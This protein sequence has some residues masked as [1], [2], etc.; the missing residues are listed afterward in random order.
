ML[1][2]L[3]G[4]GVLLLLVGALAA[5]AGGGT[6]TPSRVSAPPPNFQAGDL[7]VSVFQVKQELD[8]KADFDLIDVRSPDEFRKSHIT[9]ARNIPYY[10]VDKRFAEIPRDK[11]VVLY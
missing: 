6:S 10:D 2:R 8:R 5:C 3:F 11:W 4:G 1:R 7:F 9:G